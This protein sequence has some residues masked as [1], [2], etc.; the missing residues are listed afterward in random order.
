MCSN[1]MVDLPGIAKN[2]LYCALWVFSSEFEPWR[3]I[4]VGESEM[5]EDSSSNEEESEEGERRAS[6]AENAAPSP[7]PARPAQVGRSY[8]T[9][10]GQPVA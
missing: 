3:T 6:D 10:R 1:E 2:P 8:T 4:H 9:V 5:D 7:A